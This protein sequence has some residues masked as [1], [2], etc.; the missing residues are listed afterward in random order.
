MLQCRFQPSAETAHSRRWPA[1]Y[2]V[3]SNDGGLKTVALVRSEDAPTAPDQRRRA[4]PTA[5]FGSSTAAVVLGGSYRRAWLEC[6]PV[7]SLNN[8]RIGRKGDLEG[9]GEGRG[10]VVSKI[11]EPFFW[12]AH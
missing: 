12:L 7:G 6:G 9:E 4:A 10:G 11:C 5:A 3:G 8:S 1:L 2:C